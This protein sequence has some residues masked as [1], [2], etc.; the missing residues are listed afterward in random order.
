MNINFMVY[1]IDGNYFPVLDNYRHNRNRLLVKKKKNFNDI[2][3]GN[4]S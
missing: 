3:K 4:F 1:K 2:V